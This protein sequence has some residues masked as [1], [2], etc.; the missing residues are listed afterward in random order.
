MQI[1]VLIIVIIVGVISGI[2]LQS[3]TSNNNKASTIT[4]QSTPTNNS[5]TN[6]TNGTSNSSNPQST[7]TTATSTSNNPSQEENGNPPVMNGGSTISSSEA[8]SIANKYAAAYNQHATGEVDYVKAPS[9]H[10]NPYWKVYLV[11][12]DPNTHVT[13]YVFIDSVT[14]EIF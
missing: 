12:N 13:G 7:N 8:I 2:A 4:N 3:Y 1:I 11:S 14:G 6:H 10:A 5:T 9:Y